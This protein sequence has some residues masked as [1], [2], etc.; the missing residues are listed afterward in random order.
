MVFFRLLKILSDKLNS[1]TGLLDFPLC[2]LADK[3]GL[4]NYRLLWQLTFSQNLEVTVLS[5]VNNRGTSGILCCS[6]AS[7]LAD[8]AP[9]LIQVYDRAE[10]LIFA[11][12][13]VTHTNL[14]EE[15]RM[16]F[17]HHNTV[18]ML[19]TGVTTATWMLA[20]L[21]NTAMASTDVASLLSMLSESCKQ[22]KEGEVRSVL[23]L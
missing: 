5:N 2:Q 6:E 3:F 9:E 18:V 10:I 23:S 7:F 1:S 17:V 15:T 20:V 21:A 16:V 4:D 13:E 12:V 19:S 14:S 8:E 11:Q 22:R